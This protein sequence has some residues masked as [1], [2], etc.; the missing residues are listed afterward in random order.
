M[1]EENKN[2]GCRWL[3]SLEFLWQHTSGRSVF[4]CLLTTACLVVSSGLWAGQ[5]VVFQ[6]LGESLL[7]NA[8]MGYNACI[9]AYGQTGETCMPAA[10]FSCSTQ[11]QIAKCWGCLIHFWKTACKNIHRFNKEYTRGMTRNCT[12]VLLACSNL[13]T[14]INAAERV[15]FFNQNSL[16]T[17]CN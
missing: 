4:A 11:I 15:F 1:V 5:D 12:Y 16:G 8:F 13:S 9:F 10:R 7:D 17:G 14:E 2:D 6:C 3:T